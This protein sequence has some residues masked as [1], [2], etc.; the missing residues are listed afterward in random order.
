MAM[1]EWSL[2]G[3]TKWILLLSKLPADAEGSYA[4]TGR[5]LLSKIRRKRAKNEWIYD[6]NYGSQHY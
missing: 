5:Q 2:Y 3:K 4:G 6:N 1:S